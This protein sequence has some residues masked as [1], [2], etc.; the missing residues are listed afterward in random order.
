MRD[1]GYYASVN[2]D[3]EENSFYGKD[4]GCSFLTGTCD[5]NKRE[6]CSGKL[7]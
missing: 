2:P 3:L 7:S 5:T 6:F 4:E 1:T